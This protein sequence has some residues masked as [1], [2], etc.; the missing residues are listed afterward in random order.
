MIGY[1]EIRLRKDGGGDCGLDGI[2]EC[3]NVD[4]TGLVEHYSLDQ[5]ANPLIGS[6]GAYNATAYNSTLGVT[7]KINK[8]LRSVNSNSYTVLGSLQFYPP[9]FTINLWIYPTSRPQWNGILIYGRNVAD[10]S[11]AISWQLTYHYAPNQ[12]YADL[13]FQSLTTNTTSWNIKPNPTNI[14]TLNKWWMITITK[15]GTNAKMYINGVLNNSITNAANLR[16]I[17]YETKIG[18]TTTNRNFAGTIDDLSF[19]S[20][21]LSDAEITNLYNG[22]DGL[23]F[24]NW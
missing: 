14:I 6:L 20:R 19:F 15:S 24:E 17:A 11:V 5:T 23:P 16:Y 2:I 8:G 18:S 1:S 3:F 13:M 9:D 22:G 21:A 7:A 12:S 10:N 4:K